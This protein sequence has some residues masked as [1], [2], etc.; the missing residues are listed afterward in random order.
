MINKVIKRNKEST[1]SLKGTL[2]IELNQVN[3]CFTIQQVLYFATLW[4][5]ILLVHSTFFYQSVGIS[6]HL[7]IKCKTTVIVHV[8]TWLIEITHNWSEIHSWV[9]FNVKSGRRKKAHFLELLSQLTLACRLSYL[10]GRKDARM[11]CQQLKIRECRRQLLR[12]LAKMEGVY[13]SMYIAY[14][15]VSKPTPW[16]VAG[17]HGQWLAPMGSW[18]VVYTSGKRDQTF[19]NIDYQL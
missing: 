2:T 8:F 1:P 9:A 11:A 10:L 4:I 3:T 16:A 18:R 5:G 15:S 17:P 19:N 6:L 14:I 12:L 7:V 13:L